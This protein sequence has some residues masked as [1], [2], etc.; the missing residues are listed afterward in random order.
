[1]G[2]LPCLQKQNPYKNQKGYSL[3]KISS[4]LPQ[5]QKGNIDRSK[6]FANNSHHRARRIRRRSDEQV[7]NHS[8]SVLFY[9]ISAHQI[10]KRRVVGGIAMPEKT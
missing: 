6:E 9:C 8:L 1:M 7:S 4:V 2:M 5:M 10:K 3:K